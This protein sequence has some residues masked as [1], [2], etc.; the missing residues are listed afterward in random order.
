MALQIWLPCDNEKNIGLRYAIPEIKNSSVSK[1]GMIGGSLVMNGSS[2][3]IS[4]SKSVDTDCSYFSYS[5]WVKFNN[6]SSTQ[7][8]YSQRTGVGVGFAIFLIG[9][10]IRFDAGGGSSNQWTTTM[11][12]TANTWTHILVTFDKTDRKKKLYIN[13]EL[14]GSG[15]AG[16]MPAGK[17]FIGSWRDANA[18]SFK[19][20]MRRFSVY[21]Q[22]LSAEDVMN[23]Y[24][25]N[26]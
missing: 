10:K 2:S 11:T 12:L 6:I 21:R 16:S 19:G 17:Y 1:T 13:G 18:Q 22:E 26:E 5:A 14:K 23:L 24:T 8:L 15:T 3:Y 25:H 9:G 20:Y 7:C 4:L